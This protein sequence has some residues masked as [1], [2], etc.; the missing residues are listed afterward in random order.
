[1][2]SISNFDAYLYKIVMLCLFDDFVYDEFSLFVC[3]FVWIFLICIKLCMLI[4]IK[5][6]CLFVCFCVWSTMNFPSIFCDFICTLSCNFVQFS[7]MIN[8]ELGHS[9][10]LYAYLYTT[11]QISILICMLSTSNCTAITKNFDAFLYKT[12]MFLFVCFLFQTLM[13][14]V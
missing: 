3:L 11:I 7:W 13:L 6:W 5:L 9:N 4:C 1:M 2:L 10:D 14:I 12:V 8:H